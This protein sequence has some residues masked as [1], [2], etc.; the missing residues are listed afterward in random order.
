[1]MSLN[2]EQASQT[3]DELGDVLHEQTAMAESGAL[4]AKKGNPA[5]K[6]TLKNQRNVPKSNVSG[7][8]SATTV[9]QKEDALKVA[10]ITREVE[11]VHDQIYL[12]ELSKRYVTTD[13]AVESES[14]AVVADT[15]LAIEPVRS[16]AK[17]VMNDIK[18]GKDKT[19]VKLGGE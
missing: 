16:C 6:N 3:A 13:L 5:P 7:G 11:E 9:A 15:N 8:E 19:T 1:E 10:R 4:E 18:E 12:T 2:Q 17:E 14:G